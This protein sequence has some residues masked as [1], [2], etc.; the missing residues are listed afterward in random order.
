VRRYHPSPGTCDL[1]VGGP[2]GCVLASP[3]VSAAGVHRPASDRRHARARHRRP[4]SRG[5]RRHGV[6][7]R[8]QLRSGQVPRRSAQLYRMLV[9]RAHEPF[10]LAIRPGEAEVWLHLRGQQQGATTGAAAAP[11]AAAS[12]T[13]AAGEQADLRHRLPVRP[14][15]VPARS[16]ELLRVLVVLALEHGLQAE[17]G[18]GGPLRAVLRPGRISQL[19]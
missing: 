10:V 6:C 14:E 2:H 11:C 1:F 13:A 18:R 9:D 4:C 5:S 3:W 7:H 16:E 17:S 15:Q 8:L 19:S 12:G